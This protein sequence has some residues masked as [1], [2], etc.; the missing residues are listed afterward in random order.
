M[1]LTRTVFFGSGT[2][3]LP[4]LERLL[5][6]RP[7][8]QVRAEVV[9]V[10]TA[11]PRPTGRRGVV[12]G[13]PLADLADGLHLP[14]LAPA[15]LRDEAVLTALRAT[16][17]ELIVLADYGRLVPPAVLELPVHGAL[18]LHPSLLP[19]HRG[20]SP[21]PATILSADARTGVTL[22]RMDEG[23]DS[24]PILAQRELPLTGDETAPELE[25]ELAEMAADL[26]AE[27]LPAWLEGSLRERAQPHDGV[28]MTRPLRRLDGRL[29]P[30]RIVHRGRERA[31]H[32]VAC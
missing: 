25:A 11:P 1:D 3:A 27:T 10:V 23:L 29:D 8:D 21:I 18:N 15:T 2:F 22:M 4:I 24:G 28:T 31:P 6:P 30:A 16:G 20:A 5:G 17:V 12:R 7:S 26:L 14:L 9:A 32:R 19:R 13:T